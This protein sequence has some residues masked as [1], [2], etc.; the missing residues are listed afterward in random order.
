MEYINQEE[1]IKKSVSW[2]TPDYYQLLKMLKLLISIYV[3][4]CKSGI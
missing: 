3:K 4:F 1:M 2:A